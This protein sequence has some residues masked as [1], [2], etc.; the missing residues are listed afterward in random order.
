MEVHKSNPRLERLAKGLG[1]HS[2]QQHL[3]SINRYPLYG[4][5][6][7]QIGA[8]FVSRI[9]E[10]NAW[11]SNTC[12]LQ[13]LRAQSSHC[14]L[15]KGERGPVQRKHGTSDFG[16]PGHA[17]PPLSLACCLSSSP[18]HDEL[19]RILSHGGNIKRIS[20][21]IVSC[22]SLPMVSPQSSWCRC[23]SKTNDLPF[24]FETVCLNSSMS[25]SS[26]TAW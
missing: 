3:L 2:L 23:S 1:G 8:Q 26:S 11:P 22:K 20:S 13:D 6:L 5:S 7:L 25:A 10:M 17:M 24:L 16:L 19:T 18:H 4:T 21:M 14:E 15:V 9:P 12:P